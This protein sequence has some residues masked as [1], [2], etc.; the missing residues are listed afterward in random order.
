[1]SLSTLSNEG[2]PNNDLLLQALHAAIAA[3]EEIL[4]IYQNPSAD[5]Q[6]QAKQDDTPLTAA[7]LAAHRA[8]ND[9]LSKTGIPILSE[10][11]KHLSYADRKQW[12]HFWLTDPLDGTK[13]FLNRNGEFTVNIALVAHTQPVMGVIYVPVH[14]TL[15]FGAA[16]MGAWRL[17]GGSRVVA[18]ELHI[19]GRQ[20]D[21]NSQGNAGPMQAA[22]GQTD[23]DSQSHAGPMQA[24]DRQT[25]TDSQGNAGPM[26][27]ADRQTDTDSQGHA[28]ELQAAGE[29]PDTNGQRHAGKQQKTDAHR[30]TEYI[31]LKGTRLP[32]K[33]ADGIYTL[34][35]SRSHMNDL[36]RNYFAL[37]KE[38]HG[39]VRIVP[40]G[41]SLK[42]C[43]VAEGSAH[44]YPRFGPTME[45]DTAA[46][47]AIAEAAGKTVTV[48][49]SSKPL[50]YNKKQL[51]NPHFIVQ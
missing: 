47:Q 4:R 16:G 38:K 49:G 18:G 8:I 32:D 24:A 50:Q 9:V 14:D 2:I 29:Q 11:G 1:M 15:Y 13:E 41:S 42:M 20:T 23:T 10:E 6:V 22:G 7:D 39:Q 33:K 34:V 44:S 36:T 21:T 28:G 46:G 12:Y 17:D 31:L 26:Q 48:S 19:A 43:L 25:D 51:I 40:A 3:G 27:A 37:M 30:Q 5:L 35:G 45:W